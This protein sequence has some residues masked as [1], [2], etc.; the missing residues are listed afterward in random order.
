MTFR[1][2]ARIWNQQTGQLQA[3]I[4]SQPDADIRSIAYSPDGRHVALPGAGLSQGNDGVLIAVADHDV[5]RRAATA[6][7]YVDAG[8]ALGL[9]G[10]IR[11][12]VQALSEAERADPFRQL[13]AARLFGQ[14]ASNAEG[15]EDLPGA[16]RFLT[17]IPGAAG[18]MTLSFREWNNI[19]WF[20]SL[21]SASD[22]FLNYC[23]K[24]VAGA[25]TDAERANSRDS[26]AVSLMFAGYYDE[27]IDDLSYFVNYYWSRDRQLAQQRNG[28]IAALEDGENPLNNYSLLNELWNE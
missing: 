23:D 21:A 13:R 25:G 18:T 4:R 7:G 16:A 15:E 2:E 27:A 8:L 9:Q 5:T 1:R 24:A 3:V 20:G 17:A 22:L 26:R 14:A 10:N 12:M 11:A 28:W 6:T 19:C